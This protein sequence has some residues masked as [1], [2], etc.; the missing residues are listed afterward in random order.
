MTNQP[1][2]QVGRPRRSPSGARVQVSSLTLT[3][4]A[5]ARLGELSSRSGQ[6]RSMFVEDLILKSHLA[7]AAVS[8]PATIAVRESSF[9]FDIVDGHPTINFPAGVSVAANDA[10]ALTHLVGD[11]LV[12]VTISIEPP[13]PAELRNTREE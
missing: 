8:F 7:A 3:P 5:R 4:E 6:S 9:T 1:P 11:R 2:T 10:E 13:E 12:K